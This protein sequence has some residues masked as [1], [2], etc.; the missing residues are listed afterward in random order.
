MTRFPLLLAF[1]IA[2][3][4]GAAPVAAQEQGKPGGGVDNSACRLRIDTSAGSWIVRG[5][6][7]FGSSEGSGTFE[8]TFT[9]EGEG[10][11]AF[12]PI[13]MADQEP[14]GLQTLNGKRVPYAL[15]DLFGSY[16]ATPR[17]GRT[18]QTP[19]RRPVV[20]A[21]HSQQVVQYRFIVA[22][23]ALQGDGLF[24]QRVQVE[25]EDGNGRL[26]ASRQI[27]LGIEVLPSATLGLS[28]AY[29]INNGQ[30]LVDLGQLEEGL[31]QVPLQLRVQSTRRYSLNVQSRN[32][33]RLRLGSTEWYV[34]YQLS[35]GGQSAS[36]TTGQADVSSPPTNGLTRSS[37]PVQFRISD[38][39]GHRA[40]VYSDI[41]TI[42]VA[43][44]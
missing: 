21:P 40:G 24:D 34:P 27:I 14:F 7:P 41:I 33:G 6:D 5:F 4:I 1:T 42:S 25:A 12:F 15:F 35:L 38:P 39:S 8:L 19:T 44:Q 2:A 36:L 20:V 9:N 18:V 17:T 30:A 28:G 11:C 16:E 29:A 10:E 32:N 37:L 26:L 22:E 13:F 23:D 3:A 43:P 31:A